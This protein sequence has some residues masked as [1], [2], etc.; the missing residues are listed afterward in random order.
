MDSGLKA[1]QRFLMFGSLIQI[2]P[3]IAKS[4]QLKFFYVMKRRR[5]IN[6]ATY[7]LPEDAP[8]PHWFFS[9]DGL[10]GKEAT[11]AS[12]R[13]ASTLAGKWKRS[14]SEICGFVRRSRLLLPWFAL[15]VVA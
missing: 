2:N 8:L 1:R 13:L 7:A 14:Y 6:T 4:T 12:R 9:I 11:A 3:Q 15:Q 10:L 5:R